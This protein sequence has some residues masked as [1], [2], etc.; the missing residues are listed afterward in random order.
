MAHMIYRGVK[1]GQVYIDRGAQEYQARLRT[2]TINT[3][4]KLIKSFNING[5][6]LKAASDLTAAVAAA[7]A[8]V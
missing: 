8:S 2:R 6:E 1:Y 4:N 3:V 5:S 7:L